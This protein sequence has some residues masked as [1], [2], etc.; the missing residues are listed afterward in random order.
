MPSPASWRVAVVFISLV[1]G[2]DR[3]ELSQPELSPRQIPEGFAE[4]STDLTFAQVRPFLERLV[5]LIDSGF[6]SSEIAE[7]DRMVRRLR[8]NQADGLEFPIEFAGKETTLIIEVFMDDIDTYAV[9]FLTTPDLAERIDRQMQRF[10]EA[11]G[12]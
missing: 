5:P 11:M 3:G 6:A 9:Y 8:L 1:A 4:A 7:V 2:T 10:L 12:Q